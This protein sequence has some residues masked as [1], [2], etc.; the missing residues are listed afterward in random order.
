MPIT[1]ESIVTETITVDER[2]LT[3]VS[4]NDKSEA[5]VARIDVSMFVVPKSQ[6]ETAEYERQVGK[7]T[8]TFRR[9]MKTY[10]ESNGK[11]FNDRSIIDLNFTPA[12]L[13]KGY[14]KSVQITLYAS[15]RKKTCFRELRD[16]IKRTVKPLVKSVVQ[17][18]EGEDFECHRERQKINKRGV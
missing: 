5:S 11:I 8:R 13:R 16:S 15:L 2:V 9:M 17:E 12:N 1:K 18:I 4:A 14:N 10:V 3:S 7:L 6:R